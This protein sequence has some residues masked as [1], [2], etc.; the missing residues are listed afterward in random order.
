MLKANEK[1]KKP[2]NSFPSDGNSAS[3]ANSQPSTSSAKP[4]SQAMKRKATTP[5]PEASPSAVVSALK[6]RKITNGAISTVEGTQ[7]DPENHNGK[8]KGKLNGSNLTVE[9][10]MPESKGRN[11]V[12]PKASSPIIHASRLTNKEDVGQKDALSA[13]GKVKMKKADLL[14]TEAEKKAEKKAEREAEESTTAAASSASSKLEKAKKVPYNESLLA[15]LA[16]QPEEERLE[17]LRT[18]VAKKVAEAVGGTDKLRQVRMERAEMAKRALRDEEEALQVAAFR[19]VRMKA[20][21][22]AAA[23]S[24]DSE[25]EKKNEKAKGTKKKGDNGSLLSSP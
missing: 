17:W 15:R 5:A 8:G 14:R 13:G 19:R 2:K 6:K 3:L 12:P 18:E 24:K 22:S 10:V 23:T 7:S 9:V 21:K 25:E 11:L 20:A 1:K 4:K 16:E